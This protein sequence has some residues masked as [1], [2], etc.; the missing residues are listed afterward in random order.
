MPDHL[1]GIVT[2]PQGFHLRRNLTQWKRWLASKHNVDWQDGFFEHRLR[3]LESA[4]E[5]ANYIRM[6]PVRA[7]LAEKP[8]D[9]PY[10]RDWKSP[11]A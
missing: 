1:H 5:K 9:W 7:E 3:S 8:T 10:I 11:E 4:I 6:N 2:F